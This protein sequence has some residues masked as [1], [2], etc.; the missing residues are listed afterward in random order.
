MAEEVRVFLDLRYSHNGE[1]ASTATLFACTLSELKHSDMIHL[2][3]L[4]PRDGE[5]A[6]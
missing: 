2:L 5:T 1:T 4:E 6:S 3:A